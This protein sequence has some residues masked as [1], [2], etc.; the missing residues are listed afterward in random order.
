MTDYQPKA[1]ENQAQ[2]Y[3]N[4]KR[5]FY[6]TESS[7]KEKY[8]CL[9]MLPYP[10]GHIHMGHVRNYTLGDIA[11]RYQALQGKSV[12]QPMGWDAFG[13]PAENA[14]IKH[15]ASPSDWTTKNISQ[16]KQQL[17][18]MGFAYDWSREICTCDESYYRWEQWLFTQLYK[19]KLIY[20]QQSTV[21]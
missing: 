13:L 1:I 6:V 3:W 7:D 9:S 2:A 20:R 12:M 10:S 19:K 21:N 16:M 5:S 8:Y 14:A 18:Q 11:S 17:M 4:Q 15:N